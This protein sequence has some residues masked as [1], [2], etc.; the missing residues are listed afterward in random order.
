MTLQAVVAAKGCSER[1]LD[2]RIQVFDRRLTEE[3]FHAY[4]RSCPIRHV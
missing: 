3:V 1:F 2:L 4:A